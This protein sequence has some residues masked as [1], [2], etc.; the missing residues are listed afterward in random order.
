[1]FKIKLQN[2][3]SPL[4]TELFDAGRYQLG[5]DVDNPQAILVRSAAMHDLPLPA[6][7]KS[8]A[9]AG[10]GVNNIP[11]E[12]CTESGIVVFNTPG[13]NANG[14]KE[15]AIAALLLTSRDIVGG[16]EWVNGLAKDIDAAKEVEKG[17][18]AYVGPE[19][20][21]KVL[22]VVGLGAV[23]AMVANA[24]L[25]L[26]ME[27][28]GYDPFLTVESAWNLSKAINHARDL[29]TIYE[30]SDYITLHAPLTPDTK[31]MINSQS[32]ALMK[33]GVRIINLSRAELVSSADIKKALEDGVCARYLTDFPTN[34]VIGAKGVIAVPHLGASTPESEDNCAIMACRETIDYLENGNIKN[35][36]NFP[37]VT[38]D[39]VGDVRICVL[40]KNQPAI[41]TQVSASLSE[42]GVNIERMTN[43]SKKDNAYTILEINGAL[44]EQTEQ[45][46]TAIAGVIKVNVIR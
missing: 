32:L 17:K 23:G 35:S 20:Q 21:G 13:A 12:K 2:K 25:A 39:R 28:W 8:I 45:K 9:R 31:E 11:I 34:D 37:D 33:R 42:H 10:A 5:E 27:V 41:L 16:I 36:V 3:I 24:A 30:H 38:E 26:G 15:L 6:S 22:G 29:K 19:L 14:V 1:M 7:L 46:I 43:R 40:H 4:G 44:P 18:A